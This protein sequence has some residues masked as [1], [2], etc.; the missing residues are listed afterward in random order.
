MKLSKC[1]KRK[2]IRQKY[3]ANSLK[4]FEISEYCKL[5]LALLHAH[6]VYVHVQCS[7]VSF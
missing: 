4:L 2:S 7:F 5:I 3:H 1:Q 6:T